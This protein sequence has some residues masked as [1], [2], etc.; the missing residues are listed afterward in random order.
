[1]DI[2]PDER[3]GRS[4]VDEGW[5]IDVSMK[6]ELKFIMHLLFIGAMGDKALALK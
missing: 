4:F 2:L 3:D 1:M 6:D 5:P